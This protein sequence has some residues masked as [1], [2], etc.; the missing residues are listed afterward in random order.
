MD[1]QKIREAMDKL[2]EGEA[3]EIDRLIKAFKYASM[4]SIV[5]YHVNNIT[6]EEIVNYLEDNWEKKHGRYKNGEWGVF[7]SHAQNKKA[8]IRKIA[9][10]E[11]RGE[12]EVWID[13]KYQYG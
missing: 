5:A 6:S 3:R 8:A 10:Q 13:I 9:A 11:G 1:I 7:V 2:E 12:I 4:G